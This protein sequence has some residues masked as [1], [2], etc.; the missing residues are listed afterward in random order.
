[1]AIELLDKKIISQYIAS[2]HHHY[3]ENMVI[4]DQLPSTNTFLTE[5]AKTQNNTTI[6]CFSEEQ[7]AGKGRLGRQWISPFG[8]NIYLSL[9]WQ[10]TRDPS[11]L[12]L[13]SAI[14]VTETLNHYGIKNDIALKWPNDVFWQ[15]RKIAGI[16]IELTGNHAVVGIGLNVNMQLDTDLIEQPWCSVAQIINAVP[17]K[18]QLAGLLLNE[19]LETMLKYQQHGLKPFV[20]KWQQLDITRGKKVVITTQKTKI[21]GRGLGI[22]DKGYFLL[23]TA[24]NKVMQFI[25]GEVSLSL[26]K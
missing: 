2:K 3:L 22:N 18:N 9:L 16:L 17:K 14:S 12:S 4:F 23:S 1:M 24:D 13:A 5:L 26:S 6:I 8:Q 25:A 11:G 21:S 20:K 19:L 10:S 15:N 7:T